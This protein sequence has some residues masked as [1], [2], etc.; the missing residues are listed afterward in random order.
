M[1]E[2][3]IFHCKC[4]FGNVKMHARTPPDLDLYPT[5]N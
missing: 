2:L 3:A 5:M 1:V 4:K